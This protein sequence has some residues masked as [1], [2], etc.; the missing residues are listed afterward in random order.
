MEWY[1]WLLIVAVGGSI[2]FQLFRAFLGA[3]VNITDS[4]RMYLANELKKM[5]VRPLFPNEC[6][7]ELA[8]SSSSTATMVAK[9][10]KQGGMY[11]K[12]EMIG[13]IDSQVMLIRMWL[14]GDDQAKKMPEIVSVI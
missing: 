11:A 1:W 5:G 9:M 12:T 7:I 13:Y 4:G 2:V 6:V 10:E 8:D 14:R 3:A